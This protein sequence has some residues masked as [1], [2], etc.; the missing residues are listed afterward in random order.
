MSGAENWIWLCKDINSED[1]GYEQLATGITSLSN[2]KASGWGRKKKFS[3]P[4]LGLSVT[5]PSFL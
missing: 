4:H 3:S 1:L 2:R 5:S